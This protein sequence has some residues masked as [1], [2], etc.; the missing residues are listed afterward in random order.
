MR[1]ATIWG[2]GFNLDAVLSYGSLE[3]FLSECMQNHYQNYNETQRKK[4]LTRAW[5]EA[6][7]VVEPEEPKEESPVVVK[8]VAVKKSAKK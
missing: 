2:T 5:D 4:F 1:E 3:N 6:A 7:A 8:K